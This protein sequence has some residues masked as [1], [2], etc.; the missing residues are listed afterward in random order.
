M[1]WRIFSRE[2]AQELLEKKRE[3]HVGFSANEF[4]V[5]LDTGTEAVAPPRQNVIDAPPLQVKTT[6]AVPS[7]IL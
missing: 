2:E 5:K 4:D 3:V 7:K 1:L 6:S